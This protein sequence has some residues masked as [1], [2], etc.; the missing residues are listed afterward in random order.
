MQS[1][2]DGGCSVGAAIGRPQAAAFARMQ[3]ERPITREQ[4]PEAVGTG[5]ACPP[6]PHAPTGSAGNLPARPRTAPPVKPSPRG[7]RL[8]PLD[9]CHLSIDFRS[10]SPTLPANAPQDACGAFARLIQ[11]CG[12]QGLKSFQIKLAW[13]GKQVNS[14]TLVGGL[15]CRFIHFQTAFIQVYPANHIKLVSTNQKE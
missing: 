14:R 11:S 13:V 15:F 12:K 4:S 8:C 3:Y 5:I 6:V 9:N 2:G 7:G 10:A 1:P